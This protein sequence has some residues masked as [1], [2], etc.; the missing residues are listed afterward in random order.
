MEEPGA[1]VGG[2]GLAA[3]GPAT[4]SG[5]T[6]RRF[7]AQQVKASAVAQIEVPAPPAFGRRGYLAALGAVVAGAMVVGLLP[8]GGAPAAAD[9]IAH[10]IA[11]LDRAFEQ[12]ASPSDAERAAYAA[13]RS[14]LKARLTSA[15]A[16]QSARP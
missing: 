10:E 8:A 9:R 4:V 2:A 11:A 12:R 7:L 5:R 1:V 16:A 14:E 6:F 13:H 3:T 15:L